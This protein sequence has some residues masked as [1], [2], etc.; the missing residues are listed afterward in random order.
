M[1]ED[2]IES[3]TLGYGYFKSELIHN[4]KS[5]LSE[6]W[7]LNVNDWTKGLIVTVIAAILQPILVVLQGGGLVFNWGAILTVGLT[8]GLAYIS[9]NLLSNSSGEFVPTLG[10][11]K[12]FTK[13]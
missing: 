13:K 6:L 1:K 4:N 3:G 9:K 7:K 8:A 5:M 2:F 12:L 11:K 10:A